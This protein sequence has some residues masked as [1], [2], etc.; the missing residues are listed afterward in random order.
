[1]IQNNLNYVITF[2]LLLPSSSKI[3]TTSLPYFPQSLQ[4]A[5]FS[6]FLILKT[7]TSIWPLLSQLLF[8]L[9]AS[10]QLPVPY[11]SRWHLRVIERI[12]TEGRELD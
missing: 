9:S 1:M 2:K 11:L 12:D 4:R 6:I 3:A 5:L 8:L 7:S 10:L